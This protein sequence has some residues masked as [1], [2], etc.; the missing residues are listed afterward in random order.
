MNP[1]TVRICE[2][3]T[4][5]IVA[6]TDLNEYLRKIKAVVFIE[7]I[8]NDHIIQFRSFDFIFIFI[9]KIS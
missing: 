4:T 5:T 8:I 3:N 6:I 7:M 9:L 1:K 2:I